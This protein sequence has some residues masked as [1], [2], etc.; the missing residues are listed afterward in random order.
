MASFLAKIGLKRGGKEKKQ[1]VSLHFVPSRR[2]IENSKTIAKKF[3]KLKYTI[4]D[5]FQAKIG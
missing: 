3:K 1:K 5:S 2:V 4:M